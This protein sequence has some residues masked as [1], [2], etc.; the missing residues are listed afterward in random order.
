MEIS[1]LSA[2]RVRTK[3]RDLRQIVQTKFSFDRHQFSF[4][5]HQICLKSLYL[6]RARRAPELSGSKPNDPRFTIPPDLTVQ[7]ITR[8][9]NERGEAADAPVINI[10]MVRHDDHAIRGLQL[11]FTQNH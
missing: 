10:T 1:A 5:R 8:V 9:N 7:R 4:D 2:L 3:E 6:V 11:F